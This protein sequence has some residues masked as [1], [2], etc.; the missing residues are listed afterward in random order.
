MR[1]DCVAVREDQLQLAHA[2]PLPIGAAVGEAAQALRYWARLGA[3]AYALLL[4]RGRGANKLMLGSHEVDTSSY[5]V[6]SCAQ[7]RTSNRLPRP[8]PPVQLAY[9]GRVVL[10][11]TRTAYKDTFTRKTH[12]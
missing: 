1:L 12:P 4:V 5:H 6:D 8:P 10:R 3:S 7:L 11:P 2:H 9:R